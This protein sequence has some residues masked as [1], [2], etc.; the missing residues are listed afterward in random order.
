MNMHYEHYE[1]CMYKYIT[2]IHILVVFLDVALCYNPSTITRQFKKFCLG[3]KNF[4]NQ[5]R[6][7]L[8]PL[9]KV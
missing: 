1:R 5:A 2:R 9:G 6:S 7:A 8:I 3:C 4:D